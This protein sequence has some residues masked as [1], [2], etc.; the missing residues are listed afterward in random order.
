MSRSGLES[1]LGQPEEATLME[2]VLKINPNEVMKDAK[3]KPMQ[4]TCSVATLLVWA[5]RDLRMLRT[6][7]LMPMHEPLIMTKSCLTIP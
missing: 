2:L 3:K 1:G 6:R 7:F 5:M 4:R